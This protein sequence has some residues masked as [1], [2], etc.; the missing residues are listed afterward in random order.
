VRHNVRD[1]QQL[2][3]TLGTRGMEDGHPDRE[4]LMVLNVLLGGGM[5]SRLF[6]SVREEA[7]LAYSIYSVHDFYRDAGCCRFRW[8]LARPRA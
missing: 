7:G 8:G 2:Y 5:S 4:A 1:L 3:L 6:Q